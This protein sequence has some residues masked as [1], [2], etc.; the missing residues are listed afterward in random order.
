[1]NDLIVAQ[2]IGRLLLAVVMVH[3]IAGPEVV[4]DEFSDAFGKT[5]AD[6]TKSPETDD[7]IELATAF[8]SSSKTVEDKSLLRPM[9]DAAYALAVRAPEGYVT[10]EQAAMG[11]LELSPDAR[12]DSLEKLVDIRQRIMADASRA[13]RAAAAKKLIDTLLELGET[14]LKKREGGLA[15]KTYRRAQLVARANDPGRIAVLTKHRDRA[16]GIAQQQRQIESLEKR[17]KSNP[18]DTVAADELALMMVTDLDDPSAAKT[19]AALASK[20][21]AEMVSL[22]ATDPS[23]LDSPQLSRLG[24]WYEDLSDSRSAV[25]AKRRLLTHAIECAIEQRDRADPTDAIIALKARVS[26][27]RLQKK[28][29]SLPT[30]ESDR[31]RGWTSLFNDPHDLEGWKVITGHSANVDYQNSKLTISN[32][33]A[34]AKNVRVRDYAVE[35]EMRAATGGKAGIAVRAGTDKGSYLVSMLPNGTI[36]LFMWDR[37]KGQRTDLGNGRV[38]IDSDGYARVRVVTQQKQIVVASDKG[39][40]IAAIADQIRGGTHVALTAGEGTAHFRKPRF[41]RISRADQEL[42]KSAKPSN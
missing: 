2:P 34:I 22:A 6:V 25:D 5:I 36:E 39:V 37:Q 24:K 16:V 4:A 17:L 41:R 28:I 29:E 26:T 18:G 19:Y 40:V 20:E 31:D 7:D 33:L 10:A 11:L 15:V 3:A 8:L 27:Q 30:Q 32:G 35:V 38:T 1:M 42:L 9:L 23:E 21:V 14:Y 12:L 13:D